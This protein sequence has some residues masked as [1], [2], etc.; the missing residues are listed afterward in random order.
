MH[1]DSAEGELFVK[2]AEQGHYAGRTEPTDTRQGIYALAPSG[3]L[4][5]SLNTR[6]AEEVVAMLDRA[7]AAWERLPGG[8][9]YL[10]SEQLAAGGGWRWLERYPEDGLVLRVHSRDLPRESAPD[11]WRAEASNRDYAWF[12][13]EEAASFVPHPLEVGAQRVVDEPLVRRLARL[14]FVDNVR[15][16]V[17]VFEPEHVERARLTCVVTA[18]DGERVAL[19]LHGEC[20]AV[21][22]GTWPISG[23]DD[24][25]SPTAQERGVAVRCLGRATWDGG[26]RRF[27]SFELV[28]L[29]ERW[30]ATQYNGRADDRAPTG[31]GYALVLAGERERVAPSAIWAYGWR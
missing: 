14:S 22:R 6:S 16:Q 15:G 10:P 8:E 3:R 30:G 25:H 12:L 18:I 28:A 13:A 17:P 4:L 26:A 9:R 23:F 11:D 1:R 7:R 31:I 5:A 19:E 20:R 27:S 21:A 29:G 24:M 2:V